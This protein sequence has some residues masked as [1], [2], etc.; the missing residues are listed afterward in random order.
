MLF[1]GSRIISYFKT[2]LSYDNMLRLDMGL[3]YVQII[4]SMVN[5]VLEFRTT[6][7]QRIRAQPIHQRM[8]E[9]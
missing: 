9:E 8:V 7:E 2:T 4:A 3:T 1:Q 5:V 6:L